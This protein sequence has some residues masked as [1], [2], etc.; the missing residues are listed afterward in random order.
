MLW[1][2]LQKTD[3]QIAGIA[4]YSRVPA[5][6]TRMSLMSLAAIKMV[7]NYFKL[8]IEV[9]LKFWHSHIFD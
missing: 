2:T 4:R 1:A 6:F 5:E 7:M 8:R 9:I 3:L